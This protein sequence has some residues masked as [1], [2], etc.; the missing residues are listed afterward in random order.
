MAAHPVGFK[1][2]WT[3]ERLLHLPDSYQLLLFVALGYP[4]EGDAQTHASRYRKPL[5]AVA[6]WDTWDGALVMD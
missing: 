2:R 4:A 6:F 5:E 3:V 1:D